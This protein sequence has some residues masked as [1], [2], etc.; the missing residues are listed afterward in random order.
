MS[1]CQVPVLEAL[2]VP[3]ALPLPRQGAEWERN[4]P[5][6]V[7]PSGKCVHSM[8]AHLDAVTCLAVDPNGVFLMSGSKLG[9]SW[10]LRNM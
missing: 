1:E 10:L 6:T 3:L 5:P 4:L 8:V 2:S 7:L 9:P